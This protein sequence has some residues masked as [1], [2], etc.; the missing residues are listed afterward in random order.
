MKKEF[1]DALLESPGSQQ[2]LGTRNREAVIKALRATGPTTQAGLAR[3]TGLSTATISNAVARLKSA[4]QVDTRP[5]VSSGRKAIL[6]QLRD[7]KT[8]FAGLEVTQR[9]VR[10]VLLRSG[11]EILARGQFSLNEPS[12]SADFVR[13]FLSTH[14]DAAGSTLQTAA[15]AGIVAAVPSQNHNNFHEPG[16]MGDVLAGIAEHA[17]GVPFFVTSSPAMSAYA[18]SRLADDKSVR[19]LYFDVGDSVTA[20]W[21]NN[22]QPGPG[23]TRYA[24]R[25]GH[26]K[27]VQHGLPCHCGNRGC[28]DTVG[29]L[30]AILDA[31]GARSQRTSSLPEVIAAVNAG[32]AAALR[33]VENAADALGQIAGA[34]TCLLAPQQVILGGPFGALGATLLEPFARSLRRTENPGAG[35][36]I[37]VQLDALGDFA[38]ATGAAHF[39]AA[40]A[41]YV[42]RDGSASG[43][44]KQMPAANPG[45]SGRPSWRTVPLNTRIPF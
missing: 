17:D 2:A 18:H 6:V 31:Y 43:N 15:L 42:N 9:H 40:T 25:I 4:G 23:D 11:G 29:S 30:K 36:R 32:D 26:M 45:N 38:S 12:S 22:G 24:G 28:L 41:A 1:S 14:T 35:I 34:V 39:A 16:L 7:F 10:V 21:V 37:S 33:V 8:V 20:G 44:V 5:A 3:L 19:L 13:M 27:V